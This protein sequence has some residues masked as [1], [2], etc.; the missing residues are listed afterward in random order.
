MSDIA[1]RFR[2]TRAQTEA[3]CDPLLVE[4]YSIQS[5]P[6]ASPPKWHLAH[7]SW[8]FENFLIAPHL[9]EYKAFHKDFAFIFNSYYKSVG[10]HLERHRRGLLSRPTAREVFEYRGHVNNLLPRALK[11]ADVDLT[12]IVELGIQHEQQHQELLLTDIKH[13]FWSNPL[14][15][16]YRSK[17]KKHFGV[18]AEK[19]HPSTNSTDAWYPV[20]GGI[21]EAGF[22]SEMHGL[23]SFDNEGPR[24]SVY[25][26]DFKI[27]KRLITNHEFL[28]F[29]QAGGYENPALWLSHGWDLVN[30]GF[31]KKARQKIIKK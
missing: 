7:T 23:F 16:A 14:K 8:F 28:E 22:S 30:I 11:S 17:T 18:T 9:S 1:T 21:Y 15:P 31:R 3:I 25:L 6:D 24:H 29:I 27:Q 12:P 20:D 4:D 10:D 26:Q 2:E 5:M 19:N 13:N